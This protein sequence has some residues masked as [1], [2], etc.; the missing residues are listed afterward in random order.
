MFWRTKADKSL[1]S[2]EYE[3][4]T[5]KYTTLLGRFE[6]Y[7]VEL[8]ILKTDFRSLRSKLNKKLDPPIEE[9]KDEQPK[10]ADGLPRF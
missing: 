3:E 6:T 7:Q 2:E 5:K 4:L 10:Y 1:K 8:E 9:K